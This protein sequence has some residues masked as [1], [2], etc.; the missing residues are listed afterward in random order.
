GGAAAP[1]RG[2][3]VSQLFL[4][5]AVVGAL[6][7]LNALHPLRRF[8]LLHLPGFFASWLTGE[9]AAHHLAWQALFTATFVWAGALRA[10]PGWLGLAI[11]LLSWLGLAAILIQSRR[12]GAVIEAALEEALGPDY[13]DRIDPDLAGQLDEGFG[14]RQRLFPLPIY[15]PRVVRTR[16]LL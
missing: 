3:M 7:T 6:F 2:H 13:Q 9:L 14:L 8:A 1:L 16:N 15:D 4:L 12:A 10:W 5:A 11:T